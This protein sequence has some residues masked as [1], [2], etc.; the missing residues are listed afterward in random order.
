[1]KRIVRLT[2]SN[3]TRLIRRVI[4]EESNN[5][6]LSKYDEKTIN[7]NILNAFKN[8]AS[9]RIISPISN[10]AKNS[11]SKITKLGNNTDDF[12]SSVVSKNL[13]PTGQFIKSASG[14]L[15]PV[16]Q[17]DDV[18][19]HVKQGG[20]IDDVA[21]FLPGKLADGKD[22]RLTLQQ[23]LSKNVTKNSL[24]NITKVGNNVDDFISGVVSKNLDETGQFIK[25]AS[26]KLIPVTQ[27]DDV[28]KY[29][30][31]GGNIDDVAKFLPS[32]LADGKDFR[33][34]LQQQLSKN[35]G[36]NVAKVMPNWVSSKW[37]ITSKP[38]TSISQLFDKANKLKQV[39]FDPKQIKVK[40]TTNIGGRDVL[41]IKLPTGDEMLIYKSTGTGAPGL[42]Q[43]GD[44]QVI[45]G[46]VPKVNNPND[47][48]WFIKNTQTTQLTKGVNPY[49]TQLDE[50]LKKN[51]VGALG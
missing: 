25:S 10:I 44:W 14:K 28:L 2:E 9:R 4:K 5:K 49:L 12:I 18:L 41:E 43:A 17:L 26:G 32:K 22:F 51:G 39:K 38:E 3:F 48:Q 33:L 16:T 30:K 21:K 42:K 29:V 31:Q 46:F 36:Q 23:Q 13:D 1:M 45:P 27:L 19:K 47:V 35:V 20:N 40:N 50:F 11:L 15:I 8:V 24:N 34:A 6:R 37:F 7:E